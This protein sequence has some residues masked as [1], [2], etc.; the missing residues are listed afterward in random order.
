MES[1]SDAGYRCVVRLVWLT[2]V[3]LIGLDAVVWWLSLGPLCFP[4]DDAPAQEYARCAAAEATAEHYARFLPW[5]AFV[6]VVAFAYAVFATS[7]HRD[8]EGDTDT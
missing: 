8:A 1:R 6:T 5:T 4:P 2:L 7:R 3:A